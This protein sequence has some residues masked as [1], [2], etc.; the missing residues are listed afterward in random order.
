MAGADMMLIT[1]SSLLLPM[2]SKSRRH[3]GD[4]ELPHNADPISESDY[5]LKS[6]EFRVWLK[7]E[8][9]KYF[10]ELTGEKARHYFRKFVKAW[11]RGK[12]SKSLYAGINP[13]TQAAS[14]LTA[15]KWSFASKG[16][17]DQSAI[18]AARNEVAAATSLT[19]PSTHASSS[20]SAS[21]S[22]GARRMQGPTLPSASD[23][24]LARESAQEMESVERAYSK[25]RQREETKERVEE[26]VGPKETG[27]EGQMEKKRV[28]REEGRAIR[29][30]KDDGL[31]EIDES[32]LMGG[33]DSFKAR[34]AQ[35]DAARK[36]YEEKN[37]AKFAENRERADAIRAK[38][39]ATME[40]FKK[41]AQERFG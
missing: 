8:K 11:N 29:D 35:R 3:Q 27:R 1:S 12:L 30:A 37:A 32:T 36:R 18:A 4:R 13:S 26:L 10:D 9:E 20:Q 24:V 28:K 6:A 17:M 22:A 39:A 41:M 15:Y 34:I 40:M 19:N 25:K 16:Q 5:F 21:A 14:S 7:D 38:D 33:G 23:L 31:A 2:S